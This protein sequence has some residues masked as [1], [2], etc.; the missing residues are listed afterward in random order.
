MTGINRPV[1]KLGAL[2]DLPADVLVQ[3]YETHQAS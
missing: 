3:A 1:R 2:L